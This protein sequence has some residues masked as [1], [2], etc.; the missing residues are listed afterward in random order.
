MDR[1][2]D[3]D[4]WIFAHQITDKRIK[5]VQWSWSAFEG[6]LNVLKTYF[7]HRI[8][9]HDLSLYTHILFSCIIK[10]LIESRFH[11]RSL[12]S[13]Y[14]LPLLSSFVNPNIQYSL[15]FV[16]QQWIQSLINHRN[17]STNIYIDLST[18]RCRMLNAWHYKSASV[19]MPFLEV[20]F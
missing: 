18:I 2:M 6:L 4:K 10:F 20:Y 12:H 1:L 15:L 13:C 3:Q 16:H 9:R 17:F 8:N 14:L 19:L 11:R 7:N 5:C